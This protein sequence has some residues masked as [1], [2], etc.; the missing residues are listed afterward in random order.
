MTVYCTLSFIIHK[1]T[2]MFLQPSPLSAGRS[3][4]QKNMNTFGVALVKMEVR[5]LNLNRKSYSR[6]NVGH[7]GQV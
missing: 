5:H 6:L 1:Y 7:L 2:Q 4:T 3:F